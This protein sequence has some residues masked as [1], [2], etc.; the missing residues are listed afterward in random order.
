MHP[1]QMQSARSASASNPQCSHSMY[2]C[3]SL[4]RVI[5]SSA[6][7]TCFLQSPRDLGVSYVVDIHTAAIPEFLRVPFREQP[8]VGVDHE[9]AMF[10]HIAG[11]CLGS[12][13]G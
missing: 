3:S 10:N 13:R 7:L 5:S 11:R 2:S 12:L 1:S 4:K 8:F 6:T 9:P